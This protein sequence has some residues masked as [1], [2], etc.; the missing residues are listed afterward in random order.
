MR[1]ESYL[2]PKEVSHE[3]RVA[4]QT[5][6]NWRATGMGPAFAR[7]GG[8]IFYPRSKL[9]EW[10]HASTFQRTSDYGRKKAS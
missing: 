8:R 6:A 9:D 1:G 4:V 2:T 3:Y 5:L 10:E 7:M